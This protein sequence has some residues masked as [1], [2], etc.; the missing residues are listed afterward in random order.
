MYTHTIGTL[1]NYHASWHSI[2]DEHLL[3]YFLGAN[4]TKLCDSILITNMQNPPSSPWNNII[5]TTMCLLEEIWKRKRGGMTDPT[6]KGQATKVLLGQLLLAQRDK[7]TS[8]F[9]H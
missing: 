3:F 9:S 7:R 5:M 8:P 4:Q 6:T 2:V 1:P